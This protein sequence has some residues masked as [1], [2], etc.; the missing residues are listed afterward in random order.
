MTEEWLVKNG[1]VIAWLE[2]DDDTF[3]RSDLANLISLNYTRSG[4]ISIFFR[5]SRNHDA[6][7]MMLSAMISMERVGPARKVVSQLK[8]ASLV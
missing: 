3:A 7:D 4:N 1:G 2:H 6:F 5:R 8:V